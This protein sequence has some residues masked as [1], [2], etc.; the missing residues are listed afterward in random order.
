MTT[1]PRLNAFKLKV[2]LVSLRKGHRAVKAR[3]SDELK[4]PA[5]CSLALQALKRQRLH[6]KDEI[7]RCGSLLQATDPAAPARPQMA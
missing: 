3:I 4:R 5:P 6:L 2:R 1:T 7:A